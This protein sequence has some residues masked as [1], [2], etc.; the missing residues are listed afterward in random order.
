ML[1]SILV[2]ARSRGLLR[3]LGRAVEIGCGTGGRARVLAPYFDEY[4]A[5]DRDEVAI[6]RALAPRPRGGLRFAV[7]GDLPEDGGS[8]DLVVREFA[9]GAAPAAVLPSLT[10]AT[11]RLTPTGIAFFELPR[12]RGGPRW[13]A[14]AAA[15]R[16]AGG[17]FVWIGRLRDRLVYCVARDTT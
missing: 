17:R 14:V 9:A 5:L 3:G 16:S 12:A 8:F 11:R 6:R 10:A 2:L 1:A 13:P 15:V 4:L 7:G